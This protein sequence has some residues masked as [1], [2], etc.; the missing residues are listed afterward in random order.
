ML[1]NS[2]EVPCRHFPAR[3]AP[4]EFV[5]L[6]AE[7]LDLLIVRMSLLLETLVGGG[8]ILEQTL[9]PNLG[10][11]LGFF[12]IEERIEQAALHGRL[13]AH[14]VVLR[15]ALQVGIS[16]DELLFAEDFLGDGVVLTPLHLFL[17]GLAV[18]LLQLSELIPVE[19]CLFEILVVARCLD[20]FDVLVG[21][22]PAGLDILK[23]EALHVV[24]VSEVAVVLVLLAKV[25]DAFIHTLFQ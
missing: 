13:L 6:A 7:A 20:G 9:E 21:F 16:A 11:D 17:P 3:Q 5:I 22:L 14:L 12:L 24:G 25:G 18:G 4:A 8:W 23:M 19:I 15:L 10:C 2:I 1:T